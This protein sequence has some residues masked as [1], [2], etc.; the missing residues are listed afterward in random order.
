MLYSRMVLL[1]SESQSLV[2]K[3]QQEQNAFLTFVQN[4]KLFRQCCNKDSSPFLRAL[5]MF[6]PWKVKF[7]FI[8]VHETLKIYLRGLR[9]EGLINWGKAQGHVF[10]P[11]Q[12]K[13]L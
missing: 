2:R 11:G 8:R 13:P 4:T 5:T 6:V 7:L 3:T 9:D 10:F 1:A 12:G